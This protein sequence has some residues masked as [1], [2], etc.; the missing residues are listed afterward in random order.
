[1]KRLA[2]IVTGAAVLA[3]AAFVLSAYSMGSRLVAPQRP[4][5]VAAPADLPVE[6]VSL[7]SA[8]G[9]VLSGWFVGSDQNCGTVVLMHGIRADKRALLARARFL[10]QAGYAAFLFDFQ[11]HGQSGGESI[12][13]GYLEQRDAAAAMGFVTARRPDRPIAVVGLSL[14]GVAAVLNGPDLGADAVV[15][16]SVYPTLEKAAIN[17]VRLHAGDL[18]LVTDLLASALLI[19]LELRLGFGAEQL[20]PIDHIASLG[21]PLLLIAGSEDRH[22]TVDDSR[23]LFERASAPKRFWLVEGAGHVDF[24]RHDPQVYA[25]TMLAFLGEHLPCG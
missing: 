11:A 9:S 20:R 1:M 17:R 24:H 12:T 19:Q 4:A 25:E 18:G 22:T 8:S 23:Q 3:F 14:G 15:L 13:F 6:E 7:E 2:I 10:R 5:E 21:A 16:E